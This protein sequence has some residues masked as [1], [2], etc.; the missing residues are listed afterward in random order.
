MTESRH[1]INVMTKN[2]CQSQM[3]LKSVNHFIKGLTYF[4]RK[5][6]MSTVNYKGQF[7]TLSRAV[8]NSDLYDQTVNAFLN[9]L[10]LKVQADLFTV[11]SI[12]LFQFSNIIDNLNSNKTVGIDRYV[13]KC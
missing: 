10:P 7:S 9:R 2:C 5:R 11:N 3:V 6:K 13:L 4:I 1:N 8:R 12:T